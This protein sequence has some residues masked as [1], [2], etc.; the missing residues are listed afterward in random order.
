MKIYGH[1]WSTHT[2]KVLT[3]LAEKEREAELALVMIPKGEHKRSDHLARHPFGKVPVL[4]DGS[5]VLF[6][7]VAINRYLDRV[8][9]G[10]RL[11][12]EDAR[13][14]ASV[15]QWV[16]TSQAYLSPN[17]GAAI[18]E[19]LFRRYLGGEQ[20]RGAIESGLR[21]TAEVFDAADRALAGRAFLAGDRFS[22]AD[23]HFMPYV[24]YLVQIGEGELV[25]K[26]PSFAA[27]WE[28]VSARP[29]WQRVARSGPQ[30]YDVG[31][32]ADVVESLHR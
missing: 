8:L 30:P 5:L 31:M 14:A 32:S 17:A 3:V 4:E 29:S 12:P 19:L 11:V 25:T 15:D 27:W 2:R 21:G 28:R 6:E 1:P 26:R 23:V 13:A 10:A 18:V 20:N 16:S 22:L 9:G 24:E 7:T